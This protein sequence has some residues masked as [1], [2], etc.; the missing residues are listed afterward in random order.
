MSIAKYAL[1]SKTGL[2]RVC[3]KKTR[4]CFQILGYTVKNLN[5]MV[6]FRFRRSSDQLFLYS[7]PLSL[8]VAIVRLFFA[9]L[10]RYYLSLMLIL[11][12]Y[13]NMY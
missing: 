10:S 5:R 7:T 3:N 13:I 12:R 2:T 8:L 1:F 4:T 11:F 9:F 6:L